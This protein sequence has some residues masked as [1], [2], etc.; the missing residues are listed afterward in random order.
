MFWVRV[1]VGYPRSAATIV[2][3]PRPGSEHIGPGCQRHHLPI[4]ARR[5]VV[6][7][8]TGLQRPARGRRRHGTGAAEFGEASFQLNVEAAVDNRVDSAVEQG[9]RLGERVHGFGD[10]VT[11]LGPDVDHMNDKIRRPAAN[12]R[13]DD[14]Q[15]HLTHTNGLSENQIQS[16]NTRQEVT[17]KQNWKQRTK[18]RLTR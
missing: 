2:L 6:L 7:G 1:G 14:T 16:Q 12:E 11:V 13:A 4:I 18:I 5:S 17:E 10:D 15:R 9:Q 8:R 3:R